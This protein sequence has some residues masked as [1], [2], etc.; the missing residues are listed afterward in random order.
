MEKHLGVKPISPQNMGHKLLHPKAQKSKN[1]NPRDA[2]R[3]TC[4]NK[5]MAWP[6]VETSTARKHTLP[7]SSHVIVASRNHRWIHSPTFYRESPETESHRASL[8]HQTTLPRR[9]SIDQSRSHPGNTNTPTTLV[10]TDLRPSESFKLTWEKQSHRQREVL[11]TFTPGIKS[12]RPPPKKK[13]RSQ[14]QSQPSTKQNVWYR[15][16]K[17]RHAVLRSQLCRKK[18]RNSGRQRTNREELKTTTQRRW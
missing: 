18:Q 15:N 17:T 1:P 14:R 16:P 9:A 7:Y 3:S 10:L 12:R 11:E 5:S 4:R 2:S 6:H 8:Q 13:A